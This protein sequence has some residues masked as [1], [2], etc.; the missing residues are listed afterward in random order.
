VIVNTQDVKHRQ[1]RPEEI[2]SA[3]ELLK[4]AALRLQAA[5]V[6]Q[7]A[8]W[9]DPPKYKR[10][11]LQRGFENEEYYFLDYQDKVIGMYRLSDTDIDYWGAQ[12]VEARYI[13]SL[14]VLPNYAGQGLGESVIQ[15]VIADMKEAN[16]YK[17]RLDCHAG[18]KKLCLY[19][20]QLGFQKVGEKQMPHSLNNL[21]ELVMDE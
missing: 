9:L 3:Y 13:H 7:W 11:W 21:Y 10:V 18:N 14:V 6:S 5:G 12:T 17:L 19:Y 16:V 8:Y 4:I 15:K 20:K 2:N 1:A